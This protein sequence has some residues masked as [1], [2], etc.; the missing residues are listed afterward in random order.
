MGLRAGNS[1]ISPFFGEMWEIHK[2]SPL[3]FVHRTEDWGG[4]SLIR[5]ANLSSRPKRSEVEGP[6]FSS[7]CSGSSVKVS[8]GEL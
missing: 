4:E 1:G 6:A 5:P 3:T 7:I 2:S 8:R